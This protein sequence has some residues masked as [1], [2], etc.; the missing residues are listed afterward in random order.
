MC[1]LCGVVHGNPERPADVAALERMSAALAH[2]G[3]DDAGLWVEGPVGLAHRRLSVLD[4]SPAGRQPMSCAGGALVT[5]YNGEIYN[6]RELRAE[7]ERDG[8]VFRSNCDTEVLLE[9]WR[10]WGD[11]A[12]HRFN[13]MFSFAVYERDRRRLVLVRDRLGIK[14]LYYTQRGGTLAFASELSALITAGFVDGALDAAALDAYFTYLY[15]PAPDT[16][17]EGVHKLRPGEMLI[18]EK[19]V[20]RLER[21]W[22]P[23]FRPDPTWD[24]D[25]AAERYL[26]LL[27]DAVRLRRISDVP[28]GAFLSGGLDSS[29]VVALL[30]EQS[31][32]RIK[33]FTIAFS[34]DAVDERPYARLVARHCGTDHTEAIL[35]CDM[36]DLLPR[37]VR[38]FGE[39]FADS[40]A[41]PTWLV[42]K[43]AREQV[44]VALSG[45]G[46][47]ELFAG[48]TWL[49]MNRAVSRY[50]RLPAAI[51]KGID[52]GLGMAPGSRPGL[53]KLQRFSR[54]S[55]LTPLE[56]FRR[57]STCFDADQRAG[58][59]EPS[60]AAA[61]QRAARDRFA[62]H[63]AAAAALS[64]D[65]RMLYLDTAMYLPDDIL[66]KVDRMSMAHALE[67]RVPLLDYR[68][69][70]F[71][72]T[73]PFA[74]KFHRGAAKRV[75]KHAFRKLL[76]PEILVERKQG[77]SLPIH[78]WF[79]GE[80]GRHFEEVVLSPEARC[81]R[82]LRREAVE[83]I[84]TAHRSGRDNLGHHLWAVLVLEH[85][86]CAF[87]LP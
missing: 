35:D 40:S 41:L 10:A 19:D 47:D 32:R 2:R 51:R 16:V 28:L 1:G 13:G 65:D 58:L 63:A 21:Y 8:A 62:E 85:W 27:G 53:R 57:R 74:L 12:V 60:L 48:Y 56:A 22:Q 49:R 43:S 77:F 17:F 59:Y 68:I 79:R 67:A 50:R 14:P 30:A 87:N 18:Y 78:R 29:S 20:V 15:I 42:S 54:D 61:V 70:E 31:D 5:V 81:M 36:V 73:L 38:H 6:F 82:L 80:L 4:L 9:A 7:L 25:G 26:E 46:G 64:E 11:A 84:Y 83:R 66:T 72:G 75:A 3:P 71:A 34:D 39:P 37:I 69:V 24:L 86:M 23:P 55:F 33:T 76:P 44:T 52:W 45:D